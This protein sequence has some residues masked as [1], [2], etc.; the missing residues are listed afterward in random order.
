MIIL[1]GIYCFQWK[2]LKGNKNALF[3]KQIKKTMISAYCI[4]C[5]NKKSQIYWRA[6]AYRVVKYFRIKNSL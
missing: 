4:A 1:S 2:D 6:I 3:H 5:N